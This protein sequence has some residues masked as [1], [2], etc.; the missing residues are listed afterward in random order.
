[1]EAVGGVR[2]TGTFLLHWNKI[3]NHLFCLS[4]NPVLEMLNS[5]PVEETNC[6]LF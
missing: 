2:A 4:L 1:M 5:A 6:N 3:K